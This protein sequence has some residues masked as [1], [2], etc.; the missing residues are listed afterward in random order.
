[1]LP[2]PRTRLIDDRIDVGALI[3]EVSDPSCGAIAVFLGCVR[4]MN[5]GRAVTGIAYS[6]YRAMATRE[7]AAIADEAQAKHGVSRLTIVHRLGLLEL[8]DVSV[9]V[10]A[11]H[12][13]RAPAL[14]ANRYVI[15]QLKRRVPIWKLEHYVD[16]TRE[17]VA[18]ATETGN[19]EPGAESP[20]RGS[21]V[22]DTG[23][24][25]PGAAF[26]VPR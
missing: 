13:H 22:V 15:E 2:T 6:A 9:A 8:G 18:G 14:D 24:P 25:V 12:P 4:E 19:S 21:V 3:A 7:M 10:V 11:A 20:T 23:E 16:G 17:W 1:M 5:E 26:P